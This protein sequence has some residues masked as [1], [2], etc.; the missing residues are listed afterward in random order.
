VIRMV[1]DMIWFL[2]FNATPASE[3][4]RARYWHMHVLKMVAYACIVKRECQHE[5]GWQP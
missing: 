4:S 2:Q 5:S 1:L 3:P